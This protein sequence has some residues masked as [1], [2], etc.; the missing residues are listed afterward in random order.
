M[1]L[2]AA[3]SRTVGATATLG[4]TGNPELLSDTGATLA[5]ATGVSMP[6]FNPLD[7]L[8]ASIAS[9]IVLS[10]RAAASHAKSLDRVERIGVHVTG[11]KAHQGPTRVERILIRYDIAGALTAAEKKALVLAAEELCTV[12]NTLKGEISFAEQEG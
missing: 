4:R 10:I 7:L 5:V 8:F 12:T 2:S 6:G 11:E 1:A 9:C 3:R